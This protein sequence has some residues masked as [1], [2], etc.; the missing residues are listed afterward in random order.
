M[1]EEDDREL[2][3]DEEMLE[4][5]DRELEL[6]EEMLEEDD[7]ELELDE[8]MLE[9][10]DRELELVA[11]EEL[12]AG[13]APYASLTMRDGT[14]TISTF[15]KS[16]DIKFIL[17]DCENTKLKYCFIGISTNGGGYR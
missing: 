13:G 1:L 3:L 8:E 7:R 14:T 9:E 11:T 5:D 6:D 10:D 12:L 15:I 17:V 4:E 2:E 16:L